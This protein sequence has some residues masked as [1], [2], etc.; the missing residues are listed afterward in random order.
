MSFILSIILTITI[1]R[2]YHKMFN[3]TYFGFSTF[4]KEIVGIFIFSFILC[5]SLLGK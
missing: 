2:V 5:S 4:I 1:Y 3:V